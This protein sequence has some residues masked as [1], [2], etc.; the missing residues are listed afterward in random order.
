[1]WDGD[2]IVELLLPPSV[3]LV[4]ATGAESSMKTLTAAVA[5][6]GG[7]TRERCS[8][9]EFHVLLALNVVAHVP[10][11]SDDRAPG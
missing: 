1:M 2:N 9:G 4:V 6:A 3:S 8:L 7:V 10:I 11:R 5:L